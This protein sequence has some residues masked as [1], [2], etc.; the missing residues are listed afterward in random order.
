MKDGWGR[1]QTVEKEG[2]GERFFDMPSSLK[3]KKVR[4]LVSIRRVQV[5]PTEKTVQSKGAS[6]KKKK[7]L[8]ANPVQRQ[9]ATVG[10]SRN[11]AQSGGVRGKGET[12]AKK[13]KKKTTQNDL[14][15]SRRRK[16]KKRNA[17]Q[18]R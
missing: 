16:A 2:D 3:E 11:T 15:K 10:K 18:Q 17:N 14:P 4:A 5:P 13:G 8:L 7:G 1:G 6:G 9:P 12:P